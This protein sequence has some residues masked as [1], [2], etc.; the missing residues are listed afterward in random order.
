MGEA[1]SQEYIVR[2][3]SAL[4][5][6]NPLDHLKQLILIKDKKV[7]IIAA[8]PKQKKKKLNRNIAFDL[9]LLRKK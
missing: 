7:R 1:N 5:L 2:L 6:F 4:I 8:K 9:M 3:L